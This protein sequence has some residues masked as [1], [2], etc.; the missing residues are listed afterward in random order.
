M[1][2]KRQTFKK[3][4]QKDKTDFK[5]KMYDFVNDKFGGQDLERLFD[6]IDHYTDNP[7]QSGLIS[8]ANVLTS[9][10]SDISILNQYPNNDELILFIDRS[11][12]KG[13]YNVHKHKHQEHNQKQMRSI[14]SEFEQ[15]EQQASE[16]MGDS[17]KIANDISI[18]YVDNDKHTTT[19]DSIDAVEIIDLGDDMDADPSLIVSDDL[20][21][22]HNF[23]CIFCDSQKIMVL[24]STEG[25]CPE[26]DRNFLI[27]KRGDNKA[28]VLNET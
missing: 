18:V 7:N 11:L 2:D 28:S 26:C 25:Y 14:I 17:I 5:L 6:V 1:E 4:N 8:M 13:Y 27:Q 12:D 24:S 22:E 3:D 16:I 15:I 20:K 10:F 23:A 21:Q 19:I 9:I